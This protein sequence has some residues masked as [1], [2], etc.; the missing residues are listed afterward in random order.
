MNRCHMKDL[1]NQLVAGRTLSVEQAVEAFDQIMNGAATAAQV[2]SMLSLI[3]AR[4]P[5]ADEILEIIGQVLR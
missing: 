1:L 5:T 3:Q 2:G 4:G